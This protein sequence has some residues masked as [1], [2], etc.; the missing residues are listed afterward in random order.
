MNLIDYKP[1]ENPEYVDQVVT[2]LMAES[3][4]LHGVLVERA[5][6]KRMLEQSPSL[7]CLINVVDETLLAVAVMQVGPLWYAPKRR[8]AR[9]LLVWV[10][11]PWR[12]S[13]LGIRLIDAIEDWAVREKVDD[14]YLSQSTGIEVERTAKL[15]QRKGYTLSGFIS[16]KRINHVHRI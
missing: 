13:T 5:A 14:L 10:A 11:P 7:K 16:H 3:P 9:D 1:L 15:Y 2:A 12:K 4:E 6:V 8:G